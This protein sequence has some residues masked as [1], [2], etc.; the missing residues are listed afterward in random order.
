MKHEEVQDIEQ[1]IIKN[2]SNFLNNFVLGGILQK[3][4]H[5]RESEGH[6]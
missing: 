2:I 1:F 4:K 5:M 3:N 6:D